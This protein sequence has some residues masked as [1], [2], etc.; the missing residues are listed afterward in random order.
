MYYGRVFVAPTVVT[1]NAQFMQGGKVVVLR[2]VDV[3][4]DT[5]PTITDKL[6]NV[7]FVRIRVNWAAIEPTQ[8][9]F[10]TSTDGPI[11]R[12]DQRVAQ[13][14]AEG[15]QVLIDFHITSTNPMP[16]W[17]EAGTGPDWWTDPN[18]VNTYWPFVQMM[19]L[20]YQ[21]YANVMG[22]ELWN[23][24][25][26]A[27]ATAAGTDQVIRW[28]AQ[29][30]KRIRTIDK[31]RAI[32]VMLRGGWDQ[33]LRH[34]QLQHFG[35]THHLVLDFHDQFCGCLANER[36]RV[37]PRRREL[38]QIVSR[39]DQRPVEPIHRH[40]GR[41]SRPPGLRRSLGQGAAPAGAGG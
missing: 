20:R 21:S 37:L 29:L 10:D 35:D 38:G 23:E 31:Q 8:G 9:N 4:A 34:A 7:R 25:Q 40:K 33:G 1:H 16:D 6:G 19:V 2:G 5:L 41:P 3:P 30:I 12:L 39:Y 14:Q 15:I 36:G 18:S 32:V 26:G 28:Q 13:Y 27:P 11:D 22:F 17:A 24:P